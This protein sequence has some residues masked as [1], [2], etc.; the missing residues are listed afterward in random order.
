[1]GSPKRKGKDSKD[2]EEKV[3]KVG[4]EVESAEIQRHIIS[5]W[6][7][8]ELQAVSPSFLG[9]LG[10]HGAHPTHFREKINSRKVD[11]Q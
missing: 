11:W 10:L 7:I 4:K 1:M 3:L 6:Q 2:G 5:L 9:Y 8:C